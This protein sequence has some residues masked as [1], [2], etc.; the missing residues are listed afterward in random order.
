MAYLVILKALSIEQLRDI[1]GFL[2][3]QDC[4]DYLHDIKQEDNGK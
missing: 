3:A 4:L 1:I 2:C